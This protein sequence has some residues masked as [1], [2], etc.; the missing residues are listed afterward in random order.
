MQCKYARKLP[1]FSVLFQE[2]I[3][4]IKSCKSGLTKMEE[5]HVTHLVSGFYF[6]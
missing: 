3:L 4:V 2:I 1:I 5:L 6:A